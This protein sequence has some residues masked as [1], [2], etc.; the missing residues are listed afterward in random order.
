MHANILITF[1]PIFLSISSAVAVR[2]DGFAKVPAVVKRQEDTISTSNAP[3]AK[4]A[5]GRGRGGRRHRGGRHRHHKQNQNQQNQDSDNDAPAESNNA[6]P[7]NTDNGESSRTETP[8]PTPAN[9]QQNAA[10]PSASSATSQAPPAASPNVAAAAPASGGSGPSD[11]WS[12]EI[13]DAHNRARS[14]RGAGNLVW[15]QDL[16]AAAKAWGDAC[17]W[18]HGG[19]SGIK[20]GAGQ[21]LAAGGSSQSTASQSGQKVVD[22]WMAEEKDYNPSSPTYSHFTQVVWKASTEL[23]CYQSSCPGDR[24]RNGSGKVVFPGMKS[25]MYTVCNYRKAGNVIGQFAQNVQK[26]G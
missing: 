14:A 23:G 26:A 21:N 2:E 22:M 5:D 8:E 10:S 7:V 4:C 24:F 18:E 20:G 3:K 12:K 16:V 11:S 19:N 6:A 15:A 1:L 17:V 13:L 9:V 25:A